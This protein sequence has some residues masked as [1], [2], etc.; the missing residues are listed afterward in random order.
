MQIIRNVFFVLL[1]VLALAYW[2]GKYNLAKE[3]LPVENYSLDTLE[4]VHLGI[5]QDVR[6]VRGSLNMQHEF[7]NY[8]ESST[9]YIATQT[10]SRFFNLGRDIPEWGNLLTNIEE[11]QLLPLSNSQFMLGFNRLT[12][13]KINLSKDSL[14]AVNSLVGLDV[15]LSDSTE[16]EYFGSI[17]AIEGEEISVNGYF[18][19]SFYPKTLKVLN[20]GTPLTFK[21]MV[22]SNML[23]WVRGGVFQYDQTGNTM[24]LIPLPGQDAN[25]LQIRKGDEIILAGGKILNV[26]RTFNLDYYTFVHIKDGGFVPYEDSRKNIVQIIRNRTSPKRQVVFSIDEVTNDKYFLG[27]QRSFDFVLES[28]GASVNENS[29]LAYEAGEFPYYVSKV[30]GNVI[31]IDLLRSFAF[32]LCEKNEL[33]T[34]LQNLVSMENIAYAASSYQ[35]VNQFL[36]YQPEELRPSL[37]EESGPKLDMYESFRRGGSIKLYTDLSSPHIDSKFKKIE[38]PEDIVLEKGIWE[39]Y[40]GSLLNVYYSSYNPAPT[41]MLIHVLGKNARDNYYESFFQSKPNLVSFAKPERFTPWLI[42]WHWPVF[43]YLIRHYKIA[44]DTNEFSLLRKKD[45]NWTNSDKYIY[46][47][48]TFPISLPPPSGDLSKCNIALY[49]VKVKFDTINKIERLPLFG[50]TT[51]YFINIKNTG[52]ASSIPVSLPWSENEFE[53]PVFFLA[54]Q[55]PSLD[56][57]V[58]ANLLDGTTIDVKSVEYFEEKNISQDMIR[59]FKFDYPGVADSFNKTCFESNGGL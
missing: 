30:R 46:L 35:S 40:P 15:V 8:L 24:L 4:G 47:A 38:F 31:T 18:P 29:L 9:S 51:R 20:A 32:R 55:T 19:H 42:N 1:A 14:P 16:V 53:F 50:K 39:I 12:K 44:V 43:K 17:A 5:Y 7:A 33:S 54:N 57:S 37:F 49:S 58:V 27:K 28:S 10:N 45:I 34:C 59:A 13:F 2:G 22:E 11:F 25:L 41:E 48:A 56:V 52:F 26:D 3:A 23:G 6:G 21:Y 36:K